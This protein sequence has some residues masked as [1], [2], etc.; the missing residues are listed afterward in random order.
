M[1][2]NTLNKI[3]ILFVI[4]V[5]LLAAQI[6]LPQVLPKKTPYLEKVSGTKV[7]NI[8]QLV[9]EKGSD[10]AELAKDNGV[11][12][13]QSKTAD[14]EKVSGLLGGLLPQVEPEVVA[15]TDAKYA[16]YEVSPELATKITLDNKTKILVGKNG[17]GGI[18]VR[19]DG[20]PHVYLVKNVPYVSSRVADWYDRAISV[21]DV[22]KATKLSI[23]SIQ[24]SVD[25]ANKEDKWKDASDK[26]VKK[27]KVDAILGLL[28]RFTAQS[29]LVE[30]KDAQFSNA[31][32]M[33]VKYEAGPASDTLEFYQGDNNYLVKRA[34]DG[35]NFVVNDTAI[36][37]L[38]NAP[39]ELY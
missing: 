39:Q 11:W 1:S 12:K 17:N 20:Q 19:I 15:E 33:T 28:S 10:K 13:I 3:A 32:A 29:L 37:S 36:S 5:A 18:Y 4:L 21:L 2:N 31:V 30:N 6:Y 23:T 22:S 25:I 34:K 26:E 24:G 27:D 38:L 14:A 35:E 7:E 9:L 8:S 16:D